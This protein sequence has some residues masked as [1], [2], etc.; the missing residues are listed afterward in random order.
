MWCCVQHRWIFGD[1]SVLSL[2]RLYST[3]VSL[4]CFSSWSQES[5]STTVTV[6][7]LKRSPQ[8]FPP[9]HSSLILVL[10]STSYTSCPGQLLHEKA[11][12]IIV[13]D[14]YFLKT[15]TGCSGQLIFEH[16]AQLVV[17][18]V[19]DNYSSWTIIHNY[20]VPLWDVPRGVA[21]ERT[22]KHT[23]CDWYHTHMIPCYDVIKYTCCSVYLWQHARTYHTAAETRRPTDRRVR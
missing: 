18:T 6:L 12:Q 11:T 19:L 1:C 15:S 13:L 22:E 21:H 8:L 5:Y 20:K 7:S 14:N 3:T 16:F 17:T 10:R 4:H 23:A 9:L 2:K